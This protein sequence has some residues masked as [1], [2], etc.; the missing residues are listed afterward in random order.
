MTPF[1]LYYLQRNLQ[2]VQNTQK[3]VEQSA[4]RHKQS[5]D[6]LQDALQIPILHRIIITLI[7]IHLRISM[8]IKIYE[9]KSI[10]SNISVS[11]KP[12]SNSNN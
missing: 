4:D 10:T 6:T 8:I 5:R 1:C 12:L 11:T 2:N 7:F 9:N 3:T